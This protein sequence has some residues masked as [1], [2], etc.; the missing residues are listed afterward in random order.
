MPQSLTKLCAHLVFS[1]KN[2]Q[3]LD[4]EIR[5]NVHAYLATVVRDVGSPWVVVGGV[6]DHV[7]ILVDMGKLHPPVEFV[8]R[9]KRESSKFIKTLG[10]AYKDFY[11]SAGRECS[12]LALP[13][14]ATVRNMCAPKRNTTESSASRMSSDRD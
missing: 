6:A 3:P 14:V 11:C 5:P 12:R 4:G 10:V 1:T 9:T 8:E 7:H 2:R 13:F